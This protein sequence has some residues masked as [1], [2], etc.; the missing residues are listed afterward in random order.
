MGS[1]VVVVS[2]G[3]VFDGLGAGAPCGSRVI[4]V[5]GVGLVVVVGEVE[6]AV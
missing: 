3:S 2:S 6:A 5:A 1:G 4:V